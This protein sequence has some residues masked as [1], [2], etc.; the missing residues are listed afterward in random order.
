[1]RIT[2]KD[3]KTKL[4][5][6]LKAIGIPVYASEIKEGI[7]RPAVFVNVFPVG[8]TLVNSDI[9]DVDDSVQI[10]Y[11]PK[12]ETLEEC[13]DI[14]IKIRNALMYKTLDVKDR[15]ITIQNM[16]SKVEDDVLYIEFDINYSQSTPQ[17]EEFEKVKDLELGGI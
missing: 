15:K 14:A 11:I 12:T 3:I 2:E 17:T 13:A 5:K 10:K 1:M 6:D 8:V 4:V 9:E 7:D 16:D